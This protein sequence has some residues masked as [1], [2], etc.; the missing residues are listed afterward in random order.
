MASAPSPKDCAYRYLEAPPS[1]GDLSRRLAKRFGY[2]AD[3]I[4]TLPQVSLYAEH[5]PQAVIEA[6][7]YSE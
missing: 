6:I 7:R 3:D 2:T 1:G 5:R 4:T